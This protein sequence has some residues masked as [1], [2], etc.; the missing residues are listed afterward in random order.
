MDEGKTRG[1]I[2]VVIKRE[3]VKISISTHRRDIKNTINKIKTGSVLYEKDTAQEGER[4]HAQDERNN[5]SAETIPNTGSGGGS[6]EA[7]T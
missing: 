1:V 4:V 5:A 6:L 3:G 7:G 2:S